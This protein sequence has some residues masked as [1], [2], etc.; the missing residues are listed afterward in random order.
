MRCDSGALFSQTGARPG[1]AAPGTGPDAG[2]GLTN[3]P[4]RLLVPLLSLATSS[5]GI[6][7]LAF[8]QMT[9]QGFASC[10]TFLTQIAFMR[11]I[12]RV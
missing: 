8:F 10:K 6:N 4:M 5:S 2:P 3:P 7:P 12:P 9:F 11:Q 1:A